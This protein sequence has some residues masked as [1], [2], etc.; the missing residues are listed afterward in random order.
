GNPRGHPRVEPVGTAGLSRGAEDWPRTSSISGWHQDPGKA[1]AGLAETIAVVEQE[2]LVA[3]RHD[4][5]VGLHRG[6]PLARSRRVLEPQQ[7]VR[8]GPGQAV[9][10]SRVT[11]PVGVVGP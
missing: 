4:A 3:T 9:L 6:V 2:K 7:I 11:E 1:E 10:R 5:R 8:P